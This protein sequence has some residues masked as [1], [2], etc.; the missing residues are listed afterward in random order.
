MTLAASLANTAKGGI[1]VSGGGGQSQYGT[2]QC[3]GA[4][5]FLTAAITFQN[6]TNKY[7][8]DLAAAGER[9][10]GIVISDAWP[11]TNDLSKDSDDPFS[12]NSWIRYYKP[13]KGDI[14][15][16]TVATNT[17]ISKDDWVKY[18]D[19]Y[20]TSASNKN[21]AIGKLENG[22]A[23]VTGSSGVEQLVTIQWGT[24]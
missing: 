7:D 6:E 16:A 15:W 24:D 23:A 11:I 9:V 22:G 20:L 4:D 3:N 17:S 12:N 18:A 8:V 5:I 1:I 14:L 10:D 13:I 19:G 21:D 2:A